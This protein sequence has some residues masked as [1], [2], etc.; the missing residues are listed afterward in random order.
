MTAPRNSMGPEV[1]RT[2]RLTLTPLS[3]ADA[4]AIARLIA[5][6]EIAKWLTSVPWPYSLKDAEA[7]TDRV[8]EQQTDHFA[9]RVEGD[10]AGIISEV[11]ELGYWLAIPHHGKGYMSEAARAMVDRHFAKAADPIISGY[12]LG[13]A[14]SARVLSKLGF[15]PTEMIERY[16]PTRGQSVALQRVALDRATWE[17]LQWYL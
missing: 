12:L 5:H 2:Q 17:R 11:D 3:R 6:E 9:I 10:F 4:P 8:E 1:I 7:F 13:N 14:A 16:V 15:E